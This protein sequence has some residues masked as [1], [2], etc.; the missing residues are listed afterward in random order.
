LT[1]EEIK[2]TLRR[3]TSKGNNENVFAGEN[4]TKATEN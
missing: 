1:G 2:G 3:L 4:G